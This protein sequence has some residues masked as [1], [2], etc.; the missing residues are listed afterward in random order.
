MSDVVPH[1]IF[2]G[3]ADLARQGQTIAGDL[4]RVCNLC[5][6]IGA[7]VFQDVAARGALACLH[8]AAMEME[9]ELQ[10]RC[11]DWQS[12]PRRLWAV[13]RK[14]ERAISEGEF[15]RCCACSTCSARQAGG[16][17]VTPDLFQIGGS[18]VEVVNPAPSL[19]AVRSMPYS[20][21][22]VAS[23]K[24]DNQSETALPGDV[25]DRLQVMADGVSAPWHKVAAVSRNLVNRVAAVRDEAARRHW[26]MV[27]SYG[28]GFRDG[29]YW[30]GRDGALIPLGDMERS[31]PMTAADFRAVEAD[32]A[33]AASWR[34]SMSGPWAQDAGRDEWPDIGPVMPDL[35]GDS[36]CG[37]HFHGVAR[38]CA[39]LSGDELAAYLV[40]VSPECR[41]AVGLYL[42]R[43]GR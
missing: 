2:C 25:R 8:Q 41:A 39:S 22:V 21:E 43:L 6:S 11:P 16:D 10:A 7:A 15:W 23:M 42:A 24:R 33:R 26:F 31:W 20:V 12:A 30:H 35:P 37:R 3:S 5:A 38:F 27:K 40:K 17:G 36:W 18:A 9:R 14:I 34:A 19:P 32:K 13:L 1:C 29:D 4:V 28:P